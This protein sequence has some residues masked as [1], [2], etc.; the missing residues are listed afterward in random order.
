M[1]YAIC[2]MIGYML[3]MLNPSYFLAKCHGIDIRTRG[4]GNAGASNAMLVF[5][6]LRGAICAL[7][8]IGKAVGAVCLT[9]ALFAGEPLVFSVTA[10]AC[11]LGHIFPFYMGFRGGKGLACLTGVVLAYDLRVFGV[12]LAIEAVVLFATRYICFVPMTASAVFPVIYGVMTRDVVGIILLAGV[13]VVIQLRHSGNVRRIL[14]GREIR[15]SYLWNKEAESARMRANYPE[16]EWDHP[17][18]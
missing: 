3:G 12:L 10:S 4:S 15:I 2:A 1:R 16:D 17:E 14:R 11:I 5:G 13:A 7:F 9:R 8:D 18:M 6:K